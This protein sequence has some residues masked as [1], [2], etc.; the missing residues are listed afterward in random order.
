MTDKQNK[1]KLANSKSRLLIAACAGILVVVI[2]IVVII[3]LKSGG[4]AAGASVSALPDIQSIP[5]AGTPSDAYVGVQTKQN[6]QKAQQ[7]LRSGGSAV[8]T[9]TRSSFIGDMS[10]FEMRAKGDNKNYR[11]PQCQVPA[12]GPAACTAEKLKL[13][14]QGVS[15]NS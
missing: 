12:V 15:K 3:A 11:A 10:P 13:A 2:A 9:I 6:V 8:P 4:S 14:R 7:A 5:G 1:P